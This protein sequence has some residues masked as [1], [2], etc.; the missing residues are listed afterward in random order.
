MA[1]KT[2]LTGVINGFYAAIVTILKIKG[3][4]MAVVD[5]FYATV[6][7]DSSALETYTTKA[8][9][10]LPY[11]ARFTKQGTHCHLSLYF[12]NTG[13]T[14]INAS[15]TSPYKIFTIDEAEL[16]PYDA[17]DSFDSTFQ[18]Y[19]GFIK[20]QAG[21]EIRCAVMKT[22][23]G[24]YGFYALSNIIPNPSDGVSRYEVNILYDVKA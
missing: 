3:A 19:V 1:T 4:L 18:K 9:S 2:S 8:S 24:G 14:T 22:T 12:R 7:V 21:T 20:T 15:Q 23:A 5:E 10:S 17:A 6:L 13:A 16:L 11:N